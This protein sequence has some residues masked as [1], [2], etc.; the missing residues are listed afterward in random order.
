MRHSVWL[1]F[2][3]WSRGV[4]KVR[5]PNRWKTALVVVGRDGEK[6]GEEEKEGKDE[7][8][9]KGEKNGKERKEGKEGKE[10]KGE[11]GVRYY[12][13]VKESILRRLVLVRKTN[14]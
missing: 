12:M 10:G 5:S 11:T 13:Q 1:R 14:L 4:N 9:G 8:N 6:N 7:K 3:C 2:F